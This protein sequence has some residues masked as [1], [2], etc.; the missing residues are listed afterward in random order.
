MNIGNSEQR[1]E[2]LN[3]LRAADGLPRNTDIRR[4][5]RLIR[6]FES[7]Q[8]RTNRMLRTF[9]R[10]NARNIGVEPWWRWSPVVE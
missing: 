2:Y 4:L 1:I 8:A 10:V 9:E 7:G 3:S 6:I 5:H